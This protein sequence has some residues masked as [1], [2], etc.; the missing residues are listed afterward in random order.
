MCVDIGYKSVLGPDGL[1]RYIKGI[2]IDRSLISADIDAPHLQGHARPYCIV[3]C[4][5]NGGAPVVEKMNWG[6]IADFMINNPPLLKKYGNQLFNA[7]AEKI[8]QTGSTW[9][10]LLKNRCL[11]VADGIYEHQEVPG[12]KNKLPYY[13]Q[14]ETK[15]PLLIPGLFNPRT[16]SFA[17]ITRQGNELFCRI[18]NSGPNKYRM[19]LL[20]PPEKAVGWVDKHLTSEE[21]EGFLKFEIPSEALHAHTVFSIRGHQSRPDGKE[22]NEYYNWGT[23]ISGEQASLF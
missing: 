9:N 23:A 22:A 14:L 6:L 15:E 11:L 3:V 7:R 10:S 13:I 8:L 12:R 1:P 16:N 17:I 2:K 5:D 18:H 21:V 19:P 4:L 20:L